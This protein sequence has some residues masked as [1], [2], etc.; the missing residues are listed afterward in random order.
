MGVEVTIGGKLDYIRYTPN[1]LNRCDK[2]GLFRTS[3]STVMAA[4]PLVTSP[5][6]IGEVRTARWKRT[7]R[8]R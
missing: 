6:D 2:V 4:R 8:D 1:G 3:S 5:L 7:L